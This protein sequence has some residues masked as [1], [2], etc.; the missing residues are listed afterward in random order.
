MI[1]PN[2]LTVCYNDT[3]LQRVWWHCLAP[4]SPS[5][6][7]PGSASTGEFRP[8]A[9]AKP[10]S[11]VNLAIPSIPA[12]PRVQQ[13][14]RLVPTAPFPLYEPIRPLWILILDF[15]VPSTVWTHFSPACTYWGLQGWECYTSLPLRHDNIN[16][17]QYKEG[18]T[19]LTFAWSK[20]RMYIKE[21][22][23]DW[24]PA[25]YAKT[26]PDSYQNHAVFAKWRLPPAEWMMA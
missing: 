22:Q 19:S 18:W 7:D 10:F 13:C 25:G 1:S 24:Q 14:V 8:A 12:S 15:L 21:M 6:V 20:E 3:L 16:T 5:E 4:S 9:H 11:A 2:C 17:N 26:K 23:C